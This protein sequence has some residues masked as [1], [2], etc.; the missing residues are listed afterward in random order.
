MTRASI[1]ISD[2]SLM[3]GVAASVLRVEVATSEAVGP[4]TKSPGPA[5][6]ARTMMALN[7]SEPF[8]MIAVRMPQGIRMAARPPRSNQIVASLNMYMYPDGSSLNLL[9]A[10]AMSRPKRER[11]MATGP[12]MDQPNTASSALNRLGVFLSVGETLVVRAFSDW[13]VATAENPTMII[14]SIKLVATS[15]TVSLS[16]MRKNIVRD[17]VKDNTA[18]MGA[19]V[20]NNGF[21]DPVN[22]SVIKAPSMISKGRH[23]MGASMSS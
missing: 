13:T 10:K 1:T 14:R 9:A 4:S 11:P 15:G 21:L 16:K 2:R 23:P 7:R 12:A 6:I 20:R 19:S 8:L 22:P 17:N 5:A 3:C 18:P